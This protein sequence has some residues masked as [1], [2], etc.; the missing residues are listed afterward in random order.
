MVTRDD[1]PVELH[2]CKGD[3]DGKTKPP[4]KMVLKSEKVARDSKPQDSL[5]HKHCVAGNISVIPEAPPTH[6]SHP[7]HTRPLPCSLTPD[8]S[9]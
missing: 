2:V 1:F 4:F 3:K 5:P 9:H 7:G 6:L 8:V